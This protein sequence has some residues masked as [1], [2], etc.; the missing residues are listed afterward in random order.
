[1]RQPFAGIP[2]SSMFALGLLLSTPS[3]LL[4]QTPQGSSV[5]VVLE[6]ELGKITI[7]VDQQHAPVTA[8]NFL[9]YV[10]A[11]LYNGGEFHR[12]VRPDNE[13][14]KDVPIQVVQARINQSRASEGF[15]PIPIE[16]TSEYRGLYHVLGGALSPIDGIDPSDLK[17]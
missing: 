15:P 10:D 17:I 3:T 8:A 12:A 4:A 9:R 11:G 6:T 1:M 16:R 7:E 14:R 13:V 2:V 5:V